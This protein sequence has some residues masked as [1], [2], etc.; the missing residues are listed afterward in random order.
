MLVCAAAAF[1]NAEPAVGT[2]FGEGSF[3]GVLVRLYLLGSAL[4]ALCAIL[5]SKA[6]RI[7]VLLSLAAAAMSCPL[8]LYMIAPRSPRWMSSRVFAG[9]PPAFFT[10]EPR[11]IIGLISVAGLTYWHVMN[12]SLMASS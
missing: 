6:R 8:C 7:A 1:C 3:T 12:R 10:P 5:I 4:F 9:P 2:E 11:A